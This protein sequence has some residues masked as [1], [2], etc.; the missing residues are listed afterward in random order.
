MTITEYTTALEAA[1]PTGVNYH[2]GYNDYV[3]QNKQLPLI[4][5]YPLN[6]KN[7]RAE[8]F[9]FQQQFFIYVKG[10]VLSATWDEALSFYESFKNNLTGKVVIN[11]DATILLHDFGMVIQ[12]AKVIEITVDVT[13]YC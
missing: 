8:S 6:W 4:R 11:G 3:N 12:Q 13:I 5:A 7:V 1:T 2:Y 9:T 10:E